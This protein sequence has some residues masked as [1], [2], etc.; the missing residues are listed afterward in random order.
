MAYS[1]DHIKHKVLERLSALKWS[2]YRLMQEL[3]RN[4]HAHRV[5]AV[6]G[7]LAGDRQPAADTVS[8]VVQCVG[9]VLT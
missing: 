4:G 6:Y 3:R 1:P 5:S 7:W 9:I 8:V 2:R